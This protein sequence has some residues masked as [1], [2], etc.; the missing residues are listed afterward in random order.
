[1]ALTLLSISE[2]DRNNQTTNIIDVTFRLGSI[3]LNIILY[4][5]ITIKIKQMGIDKNQA[6]YVLTKRLKYYSVVLE[7]SRLFS[8]PY[9]LIYHPDSSIDNPANVS[10]IQTI[11]CLLEYI[12]TRKK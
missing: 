5:A 2:A 11:I 10:I 4:I 9:Q 7:L 12:F 8:T 1:M 6:L 3:L